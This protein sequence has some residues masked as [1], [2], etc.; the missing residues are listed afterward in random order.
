MP[1]LAG[2]LRLACL[3]VEL[4]FMLAWTLLLISPTCHIYL[5][6]RIPLSSPRLSQ[7]NQ[8]L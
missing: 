2:R 7:L 1:S 8:L 3:D 4:P 5:P 6:H